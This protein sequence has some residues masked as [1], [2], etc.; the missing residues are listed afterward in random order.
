M[1]A[2]DLSARGPGGVAL[3]MPDDVRETFEPS[4]DHDGH[5]GADGRGVR[6]LEWSWDP[7][8]DDTWTVTAY[9]FL[10]RD[11]DDSVTSAHET[12]RVGLFGRQDWMRLLIDAGFTPMTVIEET[13]EDRTPR[14]VFV[15]HRPA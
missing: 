7:D 9:T 8:P 5:D 15:G 13:S 6:H 10:L 4:S 3:F 14:D 1:V 12:H 11:R 2:A